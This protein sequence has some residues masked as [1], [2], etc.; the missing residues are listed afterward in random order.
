[1]STI[2]FWGD[3][4]PEQ[5]PDPRLVQKLTG[6]LPLICNL[7]APLTTRPVRGAKSTHLFADP[8]GVDLLNGAGVVAVHLA[9]NHML[10]AGHAGLEETQAHLASRQIQCIGLL[11]DRQKSA[12]ARFEWDGVLVGII[13][14]GE[15]CPP[16]LAPLDEAAMVARVREL[17]G[18]VDRLIVSIHWG[19]EYVHA[20]SPA[21]QRIAR[22]LL[23]AGA[24]LVV[25]HHSHVAGRIEYTEHGAIAYSLGNASLWVAEA[26]SR[27]HSRLGLQ[28]KYDLVTGALTPETL[29][30]GECPPHLWPSAPPDAPEA[31]PGGPGWNAYLREAG[32]IYLESQAKGWRRRF[33][34]YGKGQLRPLLRWFVSRMFL[35]MA[36]GYLLAVPRERSRRE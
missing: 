11:D 12:A 30:Q 33:R 26:E 25:G 23:A 36:W 21:Q 13:G 18:S 27:P 34:K 2:C 9:N 14:Y 32:P 22:R 17:S 31:L 1:M 20:P 24:D 10:D 7:E 5:L 15:Y 16:P 8:A 6:G 29:F 28:L 4:H 3:T 35:R 19:I